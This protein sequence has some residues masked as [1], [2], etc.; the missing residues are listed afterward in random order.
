MG[1]FFKE[2][3]AAVAERILREKRGQVALEE[4]TSMWAKFT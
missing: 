3:A 1:F 2:S 4:S